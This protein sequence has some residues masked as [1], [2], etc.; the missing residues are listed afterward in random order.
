MIPEEFWCIAYYIILYVLILYHAIILGN[1]NTD[2]NTDPVA[3]SV[4]HSYRYLVGIQGISTMEVT[5]R[6]ITVVW[7]APWKV[8]EGHHS[9][10]RINAGGGHGKRDQH[11][12]RIDKRV[13]RRGKISSLATTVQYRT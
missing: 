5:E 4:L 13:T 12:T 3:R 1:T 10:D 2:T 6:T 11:I 7:V 8:R 9:P